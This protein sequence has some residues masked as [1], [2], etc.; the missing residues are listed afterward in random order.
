MDNPFIVIFN[1]W[2]ALGC[3]YWMYIFFT[4]EGAEKRNGVDKYELLDRIIQIMFLHV[5]LIICVIHIV[6]L[7]NNK[8]LR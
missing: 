1:T 4:K 7:G 8:F 3:L 5:T 2:T 6:I